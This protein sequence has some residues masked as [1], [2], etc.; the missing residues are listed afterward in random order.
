MISVPKGEQ[1]HL[2]LYV[3]S[4]LLGWV[5]VSSDEFPHGMDYED[6]L[7]WTLASYGF[8]QREAEEQLFYMYAL[9]NDMAL[10]HVDLNKLPKNSPELEVDYIFYNVKVKC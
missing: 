5:N 1:Q 8:K 10:T 3:R 4:P 6:S 7:V 9:V 2:S